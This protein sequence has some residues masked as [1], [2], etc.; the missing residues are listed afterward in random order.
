[1]MVILLT[2]ICITRPQWVKDKRTFHQC[3]LCCSSDLIEIIFVVS[4][5]PDTKSCSL[6]ISWFTYLVRTISEFYC[7]QFLTSGIK[8]KCHLHLICIMGEKSWEI[9]I[10]VTIHFVVAREV[11]LGIKFIYETKTEVFI[12]LYH[13]REWTMIQVSISW[14]HFR[15]WI[16]INNSN[17]HWNQNIVTI[18]SLPN[19]GLVISWLW[20]QRSGSALV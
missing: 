3:F 2:H 9:Y 13:F 7:N 5:F 18:I 12:S 16:S 6:H 14:Y 17:T 10:P 8:A 4:L 11:H 1:M 20:H 19:C 15:E